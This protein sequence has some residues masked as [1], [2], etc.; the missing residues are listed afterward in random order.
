MTNKELINRLSDNDSLS[1][2]ENARLLEATTDL[3]VEALLEGKTVQIQNFGSFEVKERKERTIIH[4]K[5]GERQTV[6]AKKQIMF[7]QNTTLKETLK[8]A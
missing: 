1:K 6:P 7:K 2:A 8:N 4:P 3:I 5:T